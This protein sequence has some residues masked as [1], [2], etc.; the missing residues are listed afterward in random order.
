MTS[1]RVT[2]P[3]HAGQVARS[4]LIIV[5]GSLL[6]FGVG[7]LRRRVIAGLFGTAFAFDAYSAVDSVSELIVTLAVGAF[8]FAFMPMYIELR[9]QNRQ[10]EANLLASRVINLL[11][12][13]V[14]FAALAVTVFAPVIVAS[15]L[16]IGPG[17]SRDVQALMVDLLR[18]LMFSMI[19][20]ALSS[21][22]TGILHAHRHFWLPALAPTV[23][24]IGIMAGAYLLTPTLGIVGLAWGA[25]AGAA[26]HLLIQ[27]PGLIRHQ[28]RWS[29]SL[30][31]IDPTLIRVFLLM[32]PRI[33][34]LIL[35]R[36]TLSLVGANLNSYL[37]EGRQS[38]MTYA[39]SI[40]NIPWTLVGTAIG[41]AVF[42]VLASLAASHDLDAQRRGLS[43]SLRAVLTLVIPS[44]V[45]LLALGHPL[46]QVLY[47]GENFTPESADLV[48]Y[49]L[50][51]Y[52]VALISQSMLDIVVRSYA[53][54]KDTLTPLLVSVFTT[55]LNIALAIWLTRPIASGGLEHGGPPLANGIAVGIEAITGLIILHFRWKGIGARQ[56]IVDSL[57]SIFAAG[58]MGGVIYLM[59]SL[60][61]LGAI[62]LLIVGGGVGAVTYFGVAL[63]LGIQEIKTIPLTIMQRLWRSLRQGT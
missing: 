3:D 25:V 8:A 56:I 27:I 35:A 38:A 23:Y 22:V 10:G 18:V 21:I 19:L 55:A 52:V 30:N 4:A 44:A 47:Q 14:G 41:F 31:F 43:G 36:I 58:V 37:G 33:A 63:A 39:Y 51:F 17:Y 20:F 11:A 60:L 6:P 45:G 50:Q 40:M 29:F 2:P 57:K 59:S 26:L 49:A 9:E 46:I 62:A 42:P 34:D 5:G 53:A 54:Q 16:G 48:Y 24:S 7:L 15:P 13:L 28:F 32:L 61:Q 12:I 1:P